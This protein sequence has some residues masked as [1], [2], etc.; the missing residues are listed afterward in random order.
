[1]RNR[2][3]R[4]QFSIIA[5]LFVAI[6]LVSSVMFTY[7]SI[8]YDTNQSQ[9][10]ILSAI[11]ETNLA[12]KQV[13]GFTVGY[14]GS[15]LQVTGDS[16]YAQTLAS[17][18]LD[19]GLENIADIRPEW[20]TSITVT[21]LSLSTNWFMNSSYSQ[22][23]LN[24]TY[25]LDGLG[26]S[27]VAYSAS[28]RL[29]VSIFPSTYSNKVCLNVT[30]EDGQP[31][32]DL[33]TASFK[34]YL[35][36]NSN[37]T[38]GMVNPPDEP[39]AFP[40]GTYLIDVPSG[41]NPYSY[42]VQVSDTRGISVAASSFSHYTGTLTFNS[43]V[44]SGGDYVNNF[45]AA[46]DGKADVGTHSNF[47][48]QQAGPDG[49]FDTLT[50]Q[51]V[52]AITQ[53][54]SPDTCSVQGGTS[55]VS[56]T[57]SNLIQDDS[58]YISFQSYPSAYQSGVYSTISLD[59]ANSTWAASS[60]TV[61]WQHTTGT[62]PDRILLI[63]V[64]AFC[65][66]GSPST[67]SS[68]YYGST[69]LTANIAALYS[70]SNPQVRSYVYYLV[71][72]AP[73]TNTITV[74][75]S[76]STAA[77]CGSVTYLNV[78]QTSPVIT[79]NTAVNSGS[80]PSVSLS[81]SGTNNKML[82]GHVAMQISSS[83]TLSDAAQQ[84]NRW[85]NSGT[86]KHGST[87]YYCAGR[88]SDK[89]VTTGTV[90]LSWTP[91]HSVNYAAI[92]LLLQPTQLPSKETCQMIFSGPSNL[93]NWDNVTWTIDALSTT[94]A[95]MTLQLFNYNTGQFPT[96]GSGYMAGTLGTP[97][98]MG[99]TLTVNAASF[100][101][102]IGRWQINFT[103]TASVSAPFNVSLDLVRYRTASPVFALNSEE[104]WINLNSTYLN[105]HPALCIYAGGSL[106][107]GLVVDVWHSGVWQTLSASLVAGWNNISIS[108]YLSIP[109][110]ALRF[111]ADNGTVQNNWQI[112][113]VLLRPESDQ[114]LFTSMQGSDAVVAVEL[115]Q[116]GTM[117]WLGQNLQLTTQ[118]VPVPPVP[119][120]SL[121]VNEVVSGVNEEVP[122]Q[123]EDWASGYTVAL[124]LTNNATV[125]GN[126][127]MVVF[128]VS[129]RVSEFT[130]WWNG[131]DAAAQTPLAYTN[132]YFHD[133]SSALSNGRLSLSVSTD[134][135]FTVTSTVV[136][137][138]T[139]S[140]ENFMRVN[141]QAST[142][143]AGSAFVIYNGTV[144]DIIQQEAE[145][146]NGAPNCPNIYA[147]IVLTLP[148]NASYYTYQLGL[149][150]ITSAQSRSL[151]DLCPVKVASPVTPTWIQT[152]N[153]TA[154]SDPLVTSGAGTFRNYNSPSSGT[155]HHWSQFTWGS[156]SQGTGIMF[157]DT[158]N[159]KLYSFDPSA[160]APT[161]S[162]NVNSGTS[163]IELSPVTQGQGQVNSFPTPN[164]FA[165]AWSG[166][167]V[168]F[169][170]TTPI[171]A[172]S[173]LAGLW[174]LAELPPSIA[175]ETGN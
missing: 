88:G 21:D 127:Q 80:S 96:G 151:T 11:D 54:Y 173:G 135:K 157:T 3:N 59:S 97:N 120:K 45:N 7:S 158:G 86:Y 166:A 116:N 81:A 159:N 26:V 73:G 72:P 113:A 33:G 57:L 42:V 68:V 130:V 2:A 90:S 41:I 5:A 107:A 167:V 53:D 93:L 109:N 71:N 155:A 25:D 6:I 39:V 126:R 136:G 98:T 160:T 27:G 87:T 77:V 29:D 110:F 4:G 10:Q 56:G 20:G 103:A 142:Y 19:T 108:Q 1:M 115:L 104:Q 171:F 62:G 32:N 106:P 65:Y 168:T 156:G 133:T 40:N 124:G 49:A 143:G 44:V 17:H 91:T 69:S 114:E 51:E 154:L 55:L 70:S 18:Y 132:T 175:V 94:S 102:A 129:T 75:F 152:E 36:Q 9:P 47:A 95:S 8:R 139:S 76:S 128:L 137:K 153:G 78:N 125:F 134:S 99:Q 35:Y 117:C 34:F 148:A 121:H 119:V 149:T 38:W 146:G 23:N 163:T 150:F 85:S 84:N 58:T 22:G 50:E 170:G 61:S 82:Y 66:T 145:W 105:A 28:S 92:A 165:I 43:T 164:S 13:L 169:D 83:Y 79:S 30:R 15:V 162:I 64:D 161:G 31:F 118:A 147:N 52:N 123:V 89:T 46:V 37:S 174:V 122:F 100:R 63:S 101:D 131:S 112:D 60:S 12:L 140:T 67:V 24:I 111:R 144:R 14:Y 138:S 141:G 74:S 16:T 172:G 48:Q